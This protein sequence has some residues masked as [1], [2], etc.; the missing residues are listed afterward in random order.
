ME[1]SCTWLNVEGDT[2]ANLPLGTYW[3]RYRETDTHKASPY[4]EFT[5]LAFNQSIPVTGVRL[6]QT[7]AQLYSNY[8]HSTSSSPHM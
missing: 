7:I 6:D 3:V 8:G 2:L 4:V 1:W 5:I